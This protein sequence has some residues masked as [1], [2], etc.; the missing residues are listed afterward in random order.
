MKVMLMRKADAD[1]ERGV[2]PSEAMLQAMADYNER[3]L[4]AAEHTPPERHGQIIHAC[5]NIRGRR[6]MGGDMASDCYQAPRGAQLFL[7]Y[8][9]TDQAKRVF[10]RLA[11]GGEVTMP[12][13]PTFWARGFGMA[14]DRFGVQW[15]IACHMDKCP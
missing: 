13:A 7:E 15:M 9:D 12:F 5:L 8:Q 10:Q 3:L 4:Q 11:E 14:T 1:T 2:M 6:L